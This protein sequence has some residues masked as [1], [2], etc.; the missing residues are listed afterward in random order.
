MSHEFQGCEGSGGDIMVGV[1][2]KNELGGHLQLLSLPPR[3]IGQI[4]IMIKIF[5]LEFKF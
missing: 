3:T 5:T 4:S 2:I 1:C